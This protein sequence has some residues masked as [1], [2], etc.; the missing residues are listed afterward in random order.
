MKRVLFS[1]VTARDGLQ[2]LKRIFTVEQRVKLI[3]QLTNCGF[4]EIEAGSLVNPKVMPTMANSLE[5]YQKTL[6]PKKFNSYVLVG[7]NKSIEDINKHKIKYF[8]LFTSPSNTFNM[9]NIN[10]DID[11]SFERFKNML[12]LLDERNN[13]HTPERQ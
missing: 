3:K 11:G 4:S 6:E 8:S 7:N 5:V 1:D 9:K 13:H 2:S 10:T 12:G